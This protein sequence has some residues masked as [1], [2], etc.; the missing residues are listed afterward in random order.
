MADSWVVTAKGKELATNAIL[1]TTLSLTLF[2]TGTWQNQL[3]HY[4]SVG[5]GLKTHWQ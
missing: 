5:I 2:P 4:I 1:K 3:S